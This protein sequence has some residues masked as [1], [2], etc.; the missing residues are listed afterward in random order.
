MVSGIYILYEHHYVGCPV[1]G[2]LIS[3]NQVS[4]FG[5][6]SHKQTRHFD[7]SN[8]LGVFPVILFLL[9]FRAYVV[10]VSAF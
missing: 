2:K 10:W 4:S 5:P 8:S 9:L 7:T 1:N 3:G 6:H